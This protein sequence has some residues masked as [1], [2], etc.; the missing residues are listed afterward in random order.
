MRFR[1]FGVGLSFAVLFVLAC[2]CSSDVPSDRSILGRWRVDD[3]RGMNVPNSFFWSSLDY[4]EFRDDGSVLG[5][6]DWP[7]DGG[8]VV[9]LNATAEYRL[10][11]EDQIEF[12]GACRHRDPCAGVYTIEWKDAGLRIYHEDGDL[13]LT[14]VGPPSDE[15]PE[16]IPGPMASPTPAASG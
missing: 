2:A 5:L 10:L 6:L 7:P 4:V 1:S 13:V 11:G 12:V 3:V 15:L 8:T 9:R 14:L 16:P